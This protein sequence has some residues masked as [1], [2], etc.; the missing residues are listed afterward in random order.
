MR[1]NLAYLV[2]SSGL[3]TA[4]VTRYCQRVAALTLAGEYRSHIPVSAAVTDEELTAV[5]AGDL[6]PDG[7]ALGEWVGVE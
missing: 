3:I 6:A 1:H 2:A 5:L 4:D 7:A